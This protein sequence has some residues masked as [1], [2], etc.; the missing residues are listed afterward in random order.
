MIHFLL[1]ITILSLGISN[2]LGITYYYSWDLPSI[3]WNPSCSQRDLHGFLLSLGR[4]M[5]DK[6]RAGWDFL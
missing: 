1:I 5:F 4:P 6:P 3:S 2:N